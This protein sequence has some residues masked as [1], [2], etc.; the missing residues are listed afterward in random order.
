VRRRG[1]Q[2]HGLDVTS[3]I[4]TYLVDAPVINC[5]SPVPPHSPPPLCEASPCPHPDVLTE[6]TA[7]FAIAL[8]SGV[9]RKVVPAER[10]VRDGRWSRER[11]S[12]PEIQWLGWIGRAIAQPVRRLAALLGTSAK[13]HDLAFHSISA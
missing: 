10:F 11:K 12:R 3:T 5:K 8:L 7:D 1:A 2:R 6:D 13:A 9:A 4:K